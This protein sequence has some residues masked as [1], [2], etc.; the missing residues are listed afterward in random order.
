MTFC[1]TAF[2]ISGRRCNHKHWTDGL[3][4]L[5]TTSPLES[6]NIPGEGRCFFVYFV[7]DKKYIVID[8]TLMS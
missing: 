3:L 1:I 2:I 6:R 5:V 8:R 4:K 7:W